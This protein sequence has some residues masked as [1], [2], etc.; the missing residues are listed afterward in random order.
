MIHLGVVE[1]ALVVLD[2]QGDHIVRQPG[3]S[4]DQ[5][6]EIGGV[7][8]DRKGSTDHRGQ[9]HGGSSLL[10]DDI[11]PLSVLQGDL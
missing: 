5:Y 3:G 9:D 2:D 11:R 1:E 7:I 8:R 6:L 10:G 4:E